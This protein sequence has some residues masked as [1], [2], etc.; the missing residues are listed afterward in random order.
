MGM[1]WSLQRQQQ[2]A[3]SQPLPT[4]KSFVQSKTIW[5]QVIAVLSLF[6][7]AMRDWLAANPEQPVAIFAALNVL[8]RFATS[9]KIV[10]FADSG[11]VVPGAD[12]VP[13]WLL[14]F[15]IGALAGL[16]ALALPGCASTT[17]TSPSGAVTKT[18]VPDVAFT[19]ALADAA[20]VA[21]KE[22]AAAYIATH[23]PKSAAP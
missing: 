21:A 5:L 9:G 10:L 7:P 2:A 4:M 13:S 14:W 20:A 8:V 6:I 1:A 22:A 15:G 16:S 23:T 19:Q 12:K 17:T 18:V 3:S 11:G